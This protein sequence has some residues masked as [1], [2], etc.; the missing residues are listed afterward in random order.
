MAEEEQPK[1]EP[2]EEE[3]QEEKKEESVEKQILESVKDLKSQIDSY[4][5][6]NESLREAIKELRE[7]KLKG[8]VTDETKPAFNF[9]LVKEGRGKN[10]EYY[11]FRLVVSYKNFL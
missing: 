6:E 3:P 8:Q 10:A 9:K 7:S 11:A 1:E 2:Q 5:Q 4:K